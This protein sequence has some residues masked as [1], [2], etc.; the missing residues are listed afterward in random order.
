MKQWVQ[1]KMS[2]RR[3]GPPTAR[4][5]RVLRSLAAMVCISTLPSVACAET[6]RDA[7]TAAYLFNPTLK[8]ARAAV[9]AVDNQVARAKSGYRP[10]ITGNLA[11][12]FEDVR[13]KGGKQPPGF[14][15]VFPDPG[16]AINLRP[17]AAPMSLSQLANDFATNGTFNPRSAQIEL[18]QNIFDGFRT[19]NAV[20][21]SE[22]LVESGREDLRAAEQNVLLNSVTAYMNVVRDQA[23]VIVRQTNVKL[24]S[25]QLRAAQERY[26]VGEVMRADIAQ[27]QSAFAQSRADLSIAQGTLD[28]NRALFGLFIGHPP[29]SLKDPGPPTKLLPKTLNDAIAIAEAENPGIV[30]AVFRERAQAHTVKQ[31]KGQLLPTATLSASYIKGAQVTNVMQSDDTRVVGTLSIPLYEAGNVSAQIREAIETL[32]QRRQQIDEQRQYTRAN[33]SSGWG[34]FAAAR[35]NVAAGQSAFEASRIALQVIREEQ[36][37]GQRTILDVLNA[38]QLHLNTQVNL[39]SFKRDLVV[40]SYSVLSGMGRLTASDIALQAELYDPTRYYNEVKDAW[41]G[42]GASIESLEDPHVLTVRDPGKTP[43]QR[44]GDGPAYTQKLPSIP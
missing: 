16:S 34:L 31:I 17:P 21:G 43:G 8:A 1:P 19:Y 7:L 29:G 6:L 11:Y 24:L 32:S 2:V 4:R 25:E 14:I 27:A 5:R 38:E 35:G 20:K 12:G 41:Y 37:L 9:R 22:A 18:Q 23:I 15:P 10:T 33:I 39:I 44:S 30:A 28:T 26:K 42:W 13:T 3:I 36:R 40:A